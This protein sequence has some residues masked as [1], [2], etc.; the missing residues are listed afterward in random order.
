MKPIETVYKGY[1]FRSRLEA[2]W[3]VFFDAMGIIWEYEKE[4][5]DLGNGI[6]YLPDFWLPQVNLWAE[7]KPKPLTGIDKAKVILLFEQSGYGVLELIGPPDFI[8]YEVP[9]PL[10]E[11][12]DGGS[13]LAEYFQYPYSLVSAYLFTEHPRFFAQSCWT[14]D[15]AECF[16]SDYIDAVVAARQAR[17][18]HG[19]CG[20]PK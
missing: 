7:V 17:F 6:R 10:S 2:R 20:A 1:R 14:R 9:E 19:E 16:G 11:L 8:E 13:D 18:E 4:G 5:F 12:Y 3:S 15:D